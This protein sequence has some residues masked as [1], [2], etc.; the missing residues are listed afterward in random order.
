MKN[1]VFSNLAC[2]EVVRCRRESD[3]GWGYAD[4]VG[5]AGADGAAWGGLGALVEADFDGGEV[6]VA[7]ADGEA[8]G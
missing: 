6:V 7:T 5:A 4:G 3:L 2:S 8:G 1:G